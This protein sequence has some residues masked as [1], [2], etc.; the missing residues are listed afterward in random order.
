M[1]PCGSFVSS[2][3]GALRLSAP[4]ARKWKSLG[5]RPREMQTVVTALKARTPAR[6]APVK[7]KLIN[8]AGSLCRAFGA[9]YSEVS[10]LGR[11]PR[12]LHFAP[13]ALS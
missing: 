8:W 11:C 9:L 1:N 10:V 5:H 3:E 12:L 6:R 4:K 13:L 7:S 2:S